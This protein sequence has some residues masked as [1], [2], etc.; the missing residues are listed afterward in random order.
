M[1]NSEAD[2]EDIVTEDQ[3][4]IDKVVK[5]LLDTKPKRQGTV[6]DEKKSPTA[7]SQLKS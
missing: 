4:Y 1:N 7:P 5:T 3:D 6:E 2:I